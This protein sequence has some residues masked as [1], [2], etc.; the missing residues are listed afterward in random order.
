MIYNLYLYK[1]NN[2]Y[3]RI[4]KRHDTIEQYNND[5]S[6]NL[7]GEVLNTNFNPNDG[8]SA[9]HL[10]NYDE[11]LNDGIMPDYMIAINPST[12][13]IA[14]RW[15]VMEGKRTRAEQYHLTIYRD[16]IAE[17]WDEIVNAPCY[18]EK[19][20]VY[21]DDP[22]IFNTEDMT[23]NQIKQ[24]QNYLRDE[25]KCQWIVGYIPKNINNLNVSLDYKKPFVQLELDSIEE[26][27]G[28]QYLNQTFIESCNKFTVNM[29]YNIN[30]TGEGLSPVF[31]LHKD[32]IEADTNFASLYAQSEKKVLGYHTG[33]NPR[34][35]FGGLYQGPYN[36]NPEEIVHKLYGSAH[37][38]DCAEAFIAASNAYVNVP[39]W[40]DDYVD[41][42]IKVGQRHYRVVKH[43][44]PGR[45]YQKSVVN[46]P[47][48]TEAINL[49]M[50]NTEIDG[51]YPFKEMT[52]PVASLQVMAN[53]NE[54]SYTLESFILD[55]VL[56]IDD[57]NRG[58]CID[59]P[60]DMWC[61]PY[62]DTI[63]VIT[64]ELTY[65]CSKEFAMQ[66]ASQFSAAL[67]SD[68]VY[69]VQLLPY[70]P[71]RQLINSDGNVF[72][73]GWPVSY[74]ED[75]G[76]NFISS[77]I[78]C[79]RSSGTFQIE[80]EVDYPEDS[81]SFKIDNQCDMYRLTS[82]TDGSSFEFSITKN[83]GLRGFN[84]YYTY[85]PVQPF[86]QISPIFAGLYNKTFNQDKRGLILR[87]DFS[88]AQTSSAWA[89]YK[90]QNANYQDIFNRQ[91]ENIEVNN[92]LALTQAQYSG[93]LGVLGGAASGAGAG[94]IIG[95]VVPGI[96]TAIGAGIGAVVGGVA[97]ALGAVKDVSM[98]KEQQ[99][100]TIDY[101]KDQFAA[102]LQTIKARPNTL[103]KVSAFDIQCSPFPLLE[104][105]S[106]TK[107][108]RDAFINKLT[109]NGMTV[110]RIGKLKDFLN[111]NK[112]QYQYIKGKIIRLESLGEEFHM[113]STIAE[114]INK[115]VFVK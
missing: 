9:E 21:R 102:N 98:L 14:S 80:Y 69:D 4:V 33:R 114:E 66:V 61:M 104:H 89:N 48:L 108:E 47:E 40:L 10:I 35:G 72:A 87:G 110:M 109:Y 5:S 7:L 95:S 27:E 76:G 25:S 82:P 28:Y 6:A 71:V 94:A 38:V 55:F 85:K 36:N 26:F 101:T 18:V 79:P 100:E 103:T 29:N 31:A 23:F 58:R 84:V 65:T 111:P 96:G 46:V 68:N 56:S 62:S 112:A 53:V 45:N 17:Y 88:L 22:A 63:Q 44:N 77:I 8:I 86:I 70:C 83:G 19:G 50:T 99:A 115:G 97:S 52:Y 24:S 74:I 73:K 113:I 60:Y 37:P 11:W 20:F 41:S 1:F 57:D 90:S 13:A 92:E 78:W 34:N 30:N 51:A 15:Y 93:S 12:G 42:Y 2:Y 91:L 32:Y 67:G 81:I 39:S 64:D 106:C 3:N 105:Y 59:S 75:I 107:T 43:T 54:V 16:V 49:L